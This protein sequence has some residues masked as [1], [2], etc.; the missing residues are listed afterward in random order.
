MS[1]WLLIYLI[2]IGSF[3]KFN[4]L[5]RSSITWF[6]VCLRIDLWWYNSVCYIT[7]ES[8]VF[9]GGMADWMGEFTSVI[10]Y[11]KEICWQWRQWR[12]EVC[13][14][15]LL[16]ITKFNAIPNPVILGNWFW[17]FGMLMP[18]LITLAPNPSDLL[19]MSHVID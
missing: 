17:S 9:W 11:F 8:G 13:Y 1:F 10:G 4:G 12:P 2:Y 14:K 18:N 6:V 7:D 3:R 19:I 5:V 16:D 15:I